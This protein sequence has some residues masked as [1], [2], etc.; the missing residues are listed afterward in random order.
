MSTFMQ[1]V[2]YG[3]PK[4]PD[5]KKKDLT[6]HP[7]QLFFE[8]LRVRYGK[9]FLLN[10][11]LMMFWLPTIIWFTIN[12]AA[13]LF[14][15]ESELLFRT[16]IAVIVQDVLYKKLLMPFLLVMIPCN[17]VAGM[18]NAAA[19]FVVRNW[20]SDEHASVWEDFKDA[21]KSNW[22]QGLLA[23]LL[24]GV[25]NMLFLV[26]LQFY[27]VNVGNSVFFG[28]ITGVVLL[29]ALI[30]SMM[31]MFLYPLLVTYRLKLSALYQN[32]LSFTMLHLIRTI[33]IFLLAMLIRWGISAVFLMTNW[34]WYWMA[35]VVLF[36]LTYSMYVTVSYANWMMR[37][38]MPKRK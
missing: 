32:S 36:S 1:R 18:G 11:I 17:A 29:C 22:V 10:M 33:G 24:Q 38:Y 35:P 12:L 6:Q 27:A 20:A 8:T 5:L 13:F 28:I 2:I 25:G 4:K 16:D 3:D 31:Q 21:F 34:S 19:T 26:A 14:S 7:V 9:L 23:G 30:F 37:K 15:V